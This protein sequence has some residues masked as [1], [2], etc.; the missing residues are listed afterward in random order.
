MR[1][2]M[3]AA[4]VALGL[5]VL[6]GQAQAAKDDLVIGIGQ[7]P[8][9][10]NPNLTSHVAASYIRGMAHRPFTVYDA[11]WELI[12]MLCVELPDLDKGTAREWTTPDGERS[13]TECSPRAV[14]A[15]ASIR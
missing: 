12:C 4:L 15:L 9:G 3:T 13:R 11:D 2:R 7:F 6:A 5:S 8:T 10:F 14:A 1:Q